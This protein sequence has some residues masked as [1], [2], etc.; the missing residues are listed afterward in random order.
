MTDIK[1]TP[2]EAMLWERMSGERLSDAERQR[3][4]D[5]GEFVRPQTDQTDLQLLN[6]VEFT[7]DQHRKLLT[8]LLTKLGQQAGLLVPRLPDE[9]VEWILYYLVNTL[10]E[11]SV[12]K[13]FLTPP[14]D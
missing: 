1:L 5:G 6:A 11:T 2:I 8:E 12:E 9:V 14:E 13:D 10:N 3:I 7:P 4:L